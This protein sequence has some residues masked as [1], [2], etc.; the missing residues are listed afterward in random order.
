MTKKRFKNIDCCKGIALL[1]VL[2]YH[3]WVLSGSVPIPVAGFDTI[4]SLGG[5]IGVTMFFVLSGFGIY[6]LLKS[7]ET[8]TWFSFIRSR[9]IKIVPLYYISILFV[10]GLTPAGASYLSKNGFLDIITHVLFIHNLGG[11]FHGSINGALWTMGVIFQYYLI[12][13][14]LYKYMQR[15]KHITVLLSIL[16]TV[17]CKIIVYKFVLPAW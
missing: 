13:L 5:E 4:I 17:A 2:V 3:Y 15:N 7:R 10:I 12:A 1:L 11:R 16:F 14:L 8:V 6:C 9:F